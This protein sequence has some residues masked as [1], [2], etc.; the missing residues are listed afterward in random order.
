MIM[1][2]KQRFGL[3]GYP[4]PKNAQGKTFFDKAPGYGRLQR[5]FQQ[6]I[7]D[8]GLGVLTAEAGVGKTAA[9]RNLCMPLPRPDYL[10]LYFCDTAVSPLDLYRALAGEL[11]VRPSHRRGQLWADLKKALV[12]MVDERNTVPVIV[13]DEAQHLSEDFLLDLSGFLNFAFDS[14]DLLT[15]WLV[16]LPA[17]SKT[18]RMHQHAALAT[19]IAV[20]V[21]LD[22][23]ERDIFLAAIDHA[24]KAAGATQKLLSDQAIE[25][26]FRSSRGVLRVASKL[27]RTALRVAHTRG[28]AFVDEHTLQA[29]L[30]EIG[31]A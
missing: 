3:T 2:E 22:P 1:S 10:V 29:T 14:R 28:Q 15:L 4:M 11:G 9:I 26:L 30:D 17:L 25:M 24:L 27:L 7:D 18:L 20:E 12:H 16:G 13:I 21:R 8:P 23:L 6:L 5:C 19:R 31:A